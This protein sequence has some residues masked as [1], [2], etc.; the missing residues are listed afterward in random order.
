M[1]SRSCPPGPTN[2]LMNSCHS[3]A[4]NS[5]KPSALPCLGGSARR[6]LAIRGESGSYNLASGSRTAGFEDAGNEL[7]GSF[8]ALIARLM[9]QLKALDKQ[10]DELELQIKTWHRSSES[11]CR[12]ETARTGSAATF[13]WWETDPAG[14]EQAGRLVS[15]HVTDSWCTVGNLPGTTKGWQD[16]LA[17][18]A[19][20]TSKCK[21]GYGGARQQERSHRLGV[22]GQRPNLP[23]QLRFCRSQRVATQPVRV[24]QQ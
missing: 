4:I 8:R 7:T 3:R 18:Q 5:V 22:A 12:L 14:Y 17:T 2:A 21:R 20:G 16:Q 19:S 6:L 24:Q 10:V 15:T 9:E 11:S 1:S 13:K 23:I